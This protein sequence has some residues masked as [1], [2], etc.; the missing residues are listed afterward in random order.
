[1]ITFS[2]ALQSAIKDLNKPIISKFDILCLALKINRDGSYKN[3]PL[4]KQRILFGF[5]KFS[6]LVS[7][8]FQAHFLSRD[9]DFKFYYKIADE[10]IGNCEEACCLVDPFCYIS[11]LSA[12]RKYGLTD[13]IPEVVILTTAALK[14]WHEMKIELEND[15][16][17][18]EFY[19]NKYVSIKR[20]T[21][22]DFVR[23]MKVK[24]I[25]SKFLHPSIQI[26][27]SHARISA[28]G[29]T[30]VDMLDRPDLCG[31]MQHVIDVW[32]EHS[33]SYLDE[34]IEAVNQSPKK[35][36]KSRAGY[37]IDE[38][39]KIKNSQVNLWQKFSQRGGSRVLDPNSPFDPKFSEKWMISINV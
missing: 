7:Q 33:K 36:I 26:K 11:H 32:K 12:M 27:D 9:N 17:G 24:R 14:L 22:P 23:K 20:A 25:E 31:G 34:I 6:S 18:E 39:L 4:Y 29:Y 15:L 5:E 21:F 28:I 37:I 16:L 1:M 35:I 3:E 2:N 8:L 38:V 30:F 13:R 10:F 19:N